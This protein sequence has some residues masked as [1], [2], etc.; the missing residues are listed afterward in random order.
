MVNFKKS[1]LIIIDKLLIK[2]SIILGVAV[3]ILQISLLNDN[4]RIRLNNSVNLD[5]VEVYS[6]FNNDYF[7]TN[8]GD[9]VINWGTIEVEINEEKK[10]SLLEVLVNG[11][12]KATFGNTHKVFLRVRNNDI[13]EINSQMY[14]EEIVVRIG[15]VTPNVVIPQKDSS[16]VV[17][18][19][20]HLLTHV[21]LK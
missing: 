4:I 14:K 20:I 12:V 21:K 2:L 9:T 15:E 11:E 17:K 1:R 7:S 6:T 16:I 3:I 18:G 5:G 19:K 13:V 10:F 8:Q